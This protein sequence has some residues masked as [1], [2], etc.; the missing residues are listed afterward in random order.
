MV[1]TKR[2]RARDWPGTEEQAGEVKVSQAWI[3]LLD[4]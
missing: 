4:K 1:E 2:G 3:G